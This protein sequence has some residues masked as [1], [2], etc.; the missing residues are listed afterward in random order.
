MTATLPTQTGGD[1]SDARRDEAPPARASHD[2]TPPSSAAATDRLTAEVT[3]AGCGTA[4]A[5]ETSD[6]STPSPAS[7]WTFP[8]GAYVRI[9]ATART[10]CTFVRWELLLGGV[11]FYDT[12]SNPLQ[13]QLASDMTV[14]AHFSGTPPTYTLTTSAGANG[15]IDPTAGREQTPRS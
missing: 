15:S 10:G 4:T 7:E 11:F 14:K 3:P 6:T 9:A 13:F 12:S 1:S 5:K 2:A 8:D